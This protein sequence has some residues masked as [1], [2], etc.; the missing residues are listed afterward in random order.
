MKLLCKMYEL[1]HKVREEKRKGLNATSKVNLSRDGVNQSS[2]QRDEARDDGT[3]KGVS[4]EKE[5]EEEEEEEEDGCG[6]LMI[7]TKNGHKQLFCDL[8]WLFFGW[9]IVLVW[10]VFFLCGWL[11]IRNE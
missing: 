1:E 5:E 8:G 6:D 11:N 4:N 9:L 2:Q 3:S 7:L 10:M